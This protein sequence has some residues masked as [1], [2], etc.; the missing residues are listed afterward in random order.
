MAILIS[1]VDMVNTINLMLHSISTTEIKINTFGN[2]GLGSNKYYNE[3]NLN[4][5]Q[6]G[7]HLRSKTIAGQ[8]N[9]PLNVKLGMDFLRMKTYFGILLN[10][11]TQMADREFLSTSITKIYSQQSPG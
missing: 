5:E 2:L 9:L 11:N 3:L 7:G 10:G 4:R 8:F 6:D 1:V